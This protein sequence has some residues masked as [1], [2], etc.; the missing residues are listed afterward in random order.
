MPSQ[1]ATTASHGPWWRADR[2]D[3]IRLL[4]QDVTIK[5]VLISAG[6]LLLLKTYLFA[7]GLYRLYYH[8]LR[9]FP[10]PP[11]AAKSRSWLFQ[12]TMDGYPE[13]TFQALHSKYRM[14]SF[15]RN[16]S[17]FMALILRE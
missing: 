12:E 4:N 14:P 2:P 1:E 15:P 10:G 3:V 9:K 8:P 13:D 7:R 5:V 6:L 17:L 16:S 11:E